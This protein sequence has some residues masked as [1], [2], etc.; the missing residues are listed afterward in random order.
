MRHKNANNNN[1]NNNNKKRRA[2]LAL[3]SYLAQV[4]IEPDMNQSDTKL[5]KCS[6]VMSLV[7]KSYPPDHLV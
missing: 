3:L 4:I 7:S 2:N 1:N 6:H 5:S